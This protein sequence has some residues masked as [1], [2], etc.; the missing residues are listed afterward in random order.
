MHAGEGPGEAGRAWLAATIAVGL[1][2][3]LAL[4][5]PAD[6]HTHGCWT[7]VDVARVQARS[8]AVAVDVFRQAHR[9]LPTSLEELARP[10][11]GGEIPILEAGLP[12]DP[13]GHPFVYRILPG[14]G[15]EVFSPGA[16]GLADS[17]DD[18]RCDGLR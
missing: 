7:A 9:R 3:I 18:A 6:R 17:E 15:T 1:G 11:A 16:D 13:W 14:G 2:G 5:G 10:L 12:V 4:R 8:L